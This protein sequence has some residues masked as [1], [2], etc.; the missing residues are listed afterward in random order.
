MI[1]YGVILVG[2]CVAVALWRIP[3][4]A[5]IFRDARGPL[6]TGAIRGNCMWMVSKSKLSKKGESGYLNLY[7]AV[8]LACDRIYQP[9]A[10]R[11]NLTVLG[12]RRYEDIYR[13]VLGSCVLATESF[14]ALTKA[15]RGRSYPI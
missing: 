15:L 14:L 7:L 4:M 11:T 10:R 2:I 13:S 8:Q 6:P 1:S 12:C 9:R 3:L 5:P